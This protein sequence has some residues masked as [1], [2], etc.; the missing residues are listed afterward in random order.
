MNQQAILKPGDAFLGKP[1]TPVAL[2][3]RVS[4]VLRSNGAQADGAEQR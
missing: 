3:R 2:L 1:F 4:D